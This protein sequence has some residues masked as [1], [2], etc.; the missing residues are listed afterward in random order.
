LDATVSFPQPL[1]WHNGELFIEIKDYLFVK[2]G[3]KTRHLEQH[4]DNLVLGMKWEIFES[5]EKKI[6]KKTVGRYF[7][8]AS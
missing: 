5:L 2:A 6:F 3:K 7:F 8:A 1:V 4:L